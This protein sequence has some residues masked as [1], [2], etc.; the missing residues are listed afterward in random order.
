MGIAPFLLGA[1]SIDV[2]REGEHDL[3][4]GTSVVYYA[5]SDKSDQEELKERE[6]ADEILLA[7][8][9]Q[10]RAGLP[11]LIVR[12]SCL[13]ILSMSLFAQYQTMAEQT[14]WNGCSEPRRRTA[15]Y[16]ILLGRPGILAS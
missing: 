8:V 4:V 12:I 7:A 15:P 14:V 10:L 5:A 9:D 16:L 6:K 1:L 13:P 11:R 3:H 2:D